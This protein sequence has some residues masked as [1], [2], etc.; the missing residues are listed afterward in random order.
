MDYEEFKK[1]IVDSIREFLPEECRN[2]SVDI[3]PYNKNNGIQ[4]DGLVIRGSENVVPNIYLNQYFRDFEEGRP[5]SDI[6]ADI[7]SVYMENRVDNPVFAPK[8]F[9]YENLKKSLIVTACNAEKNAEL[10][11]K[12][13][14]EL[15]EDL[16]LTYRA[17]VSMPEKG[18]GT[19]LIRNEHLARWGIDEQTLKEDAWKSMKQISSPS[20]SSMQD[21][22][23]EMLQ[24]SFPEGMIKE[25]ENPLQMYVLTNKDRYQGA[26][27]MFDQ[28]TMSA[29]AERL[30]SSLVVLPSSVHETILLK[31]NPEM[32]YE[33]LREMVKDVNTSQVSPD[34][35]LSDNV[36]RFDRESQILSLASEPE[37]MQGMNMGM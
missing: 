26:V 1:E 5:L 21:I 28:E 3:H 31:E 35:V 18:I 7:A 22:I 12:V 14:H 30:N 24:D 20:I 23:S 36:Y 4:L 29:I 9:S 34:E 25:T 13:P 8:E 37:Q 11:E 32:D 16:A 15:R 19:I 17:K 6:K 10:L 27:Y 2:H 33:E